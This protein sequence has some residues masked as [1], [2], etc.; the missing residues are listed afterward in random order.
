MVREGWREIGFTQFVPD[1]LEII[2]ESLEHLNN[3][4][5]LKTV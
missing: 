1:S 5:K 4:E 3:Q 2:P